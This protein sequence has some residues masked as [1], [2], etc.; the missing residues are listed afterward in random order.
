MAENNSNSNYRPR[1][2]QRG[3]RDSQRRGNY[4]RDGQNISDNRD[5]RDNRSSGYN[6]SGNR[7]S[8]DNR[9]S[10]Y[11]RDGNRGS[12]YNR[13]DNRGQGRTSGYNNSRD[14]QK[15]KFPPRVA[16]SKRLGA[17][18]LKGVFH[19]NKYIY[20]ESIA[21][22][23]QVYGENLKTQ[24]GVVYR[25]WNPTRSKLGAAIK[26]GTSQIGI[27][28]GASVLYLGASSG[29]TVSH[30]ADMVGKEGSVYALEF[31]PTSTRQLFKVVDKW[32]NVAPLL[33][34]ASKPEE[35][36]D[37]VPAVDV[38][39]QDIAQRQQLRIFVENC[40]SYLK[41]GGFGLLAVKARSIDV[42]RKP[43]EIFA[44]VEAELLKY[45][46]IVDKRVLD[47]FEKDHI[48]FVIK[49]K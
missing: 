6:R 44:E 13:S 29:T 46:P 31:S 19:D 7:D 23:T 2:G 42:T 11:N 5:S 9:S 37:L 49:K 25:E 1:N 39:F 24:D 4:S 28:P 41:Q 43:K 38:V 16:Q 20:T 14:N 3:S 22:A 17:H 27:V 12:G 34:D 21:G 40:Q 18:R 36:M 8:R 45:M 15:P 48:M 47:P 26:L 32:P 33:F 30:V 10:G 35:Y